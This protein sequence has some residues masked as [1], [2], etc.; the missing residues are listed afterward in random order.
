LFWQRCVGAQDVGDPPVAVL[1]ALIE[2]IKQLP[3]WG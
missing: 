1:L 2:F 3:I